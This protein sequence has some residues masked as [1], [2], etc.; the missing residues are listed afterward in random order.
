ML[1]L[2]ID[3]FKDTLLMLPLLYVSYLVIE[4]F[5][6]KGTSDSFFFSLQKY[7]PLIGALI[8]IIPQCGFSIIGSILFLQN[9]IT[10]GT[11]ISIFIATS[12]EMI[13]VLI[14]HTNLYNSM[15]LILGIK[16]VVGMGVGYLVDMIFGKKIILFSEMEDEAE[17]EEE[18]SDEE[19][20]TSC[21]CCYPQY[22]IYISALLRSLKVYA[23]I[24]VITLVLNMIVSFGGE[25][26]L[27][28]ILLKGSIFQPIIATIIGF[29]PN[30]IASVILT[31]L[32]V[33]QS[34]SLASLVA[35]LISNAGL[36]VLCLIQYGASKDQLIK[37]I[38]ILFLTGS[39]TGIIMS[40]I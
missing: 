11:L 33:Q 7:G 19:Q 24:A 34:I 37:V 18:N 30:C 17:E 8:G 38:S 16:I 5:E 31:E 40:L 12:D 22:P 6:R 21:P 23:F 20:G 27:S 36:G 4:Y 25:V 14:A 9:N 39:I 29:I 1:D 2:V 13:P 35:G 26:F 10:L 3:M 15:L 28:N 32:Y